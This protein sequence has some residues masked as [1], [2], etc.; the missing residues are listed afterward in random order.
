[1]SVAR[2]DDGRRRK[3]QH[4]DSAKMAMAVVSSFQS[5]VFGTT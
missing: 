5:Y 4:N 2:D 3:D 1:M